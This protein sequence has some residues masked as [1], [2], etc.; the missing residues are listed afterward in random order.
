MEEY[1]LEKNGS[2]LVYC[3]SECSKGWVK[4][5]EDGGDGVATECSMDVLHTDLIEIIWD[6]IKAGEDNVLPMYGF[7]D[8]NWTMEELHQAYKTKTGNDFVA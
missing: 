6:V 2:G 8:R 4:T 1:K 3:G 5:Y 7:N